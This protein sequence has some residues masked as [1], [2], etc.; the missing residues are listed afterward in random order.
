V[1][2]LTEPLEMGGNDLYSDRSELFEAIANDLL[3]SV[4]NQHFSPFLTRLKEKGI[5]S[6]VWRTV[7]AGNDIIIIAGNGLP[8]K[9]N[10]EQSDML[11]DSF[12]LKRA[13][14][15]G[16]HIVAVEMLEVEYSAITEYEKLGVE[17][18]PEVNTVYGRLALVS[19]LEGSIAKDED[20]SKLR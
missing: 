7:N 15:A 10:N 17:I 4:S 14:D 12:V 18:I 19:L 3:E 2:V 20:W 8:D 11:F 6:G 5:V 13:L 9:I 1:G 16:M